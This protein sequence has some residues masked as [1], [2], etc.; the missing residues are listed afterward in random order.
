MTALNIQSV[1]WFGT[2]SNSTREVKLKIYGSDETLTLP[3]QVT[4]KVV[5]VR[6]MLAGKLACDWES[7]TFIQQGVGGKARTLRDNEEIRTN[8]LVKGAK[9]F[10]R[11]RMRWPHLHAIIGAGHAGLRQA[12]SYQ[13]EGHQNYV[14]FDRHDIVGGTAWVDNANPTS[15]LQTEL[16]V[17]HLQYDPAYPWPRGMKTQ[18]SR[19]ELL[20]HFAQV[21]EEYGITPHL[22]LGSDVQSMDVV[23]DPGDPSGFMQ[24]YHLSV[25]KADGSTPPG[26][27]AILEVSSVACFPGGLINPKRV[28]YKGEEIFEGQMGYGMFNEFDYS[29]VK[30]EGVAIIGFGAFATENVRTCVEHSAKMITIVCRRK[31][32]AM[33]RIVS[34]MTNQSFYPVPGKMCMEMMECMYELAGDDPWGYYAVVT[35]EKRITVTLRQASRFGIGDVFFLARYFGKCDVLVGT[36]KRLKRDGVQLETGETFDCQHIIKV[37]GFVGDFT[38]DKTMGIKKMEGFHVNSDFRRLIWAENPGIDAGKFGGTSF[39]PAAIATSEMQ[40]WFLNYIG[41][42]FM[43][44]GVGMLP[45][46]KQDPDAE[47]PTYIWEPR[48]GSTISMLYANCPSIGELSLPYQQFNRD[49][50]LEMHPVEQFID[51]CAEE[52]YNYAKMM[53]EEGCEKEVPPYP[54]TYAYVHEMCERQDKE[55]KEDQDRQN[56]RMMAAS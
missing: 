15:K 38:V 48:N 4:T 16:A 5:E 31:N 28:E 24:T 49:R 23:K 13:K 41:D 44:I 35:T 3:L 32:M 55:G 25:A 33:P 29:R 9:S 26:E 21:C 37:L 10:T 27:E 45:T 19:L 1:P 20:E 11:E 51:E 40:S 14:C 42:S 47:R 34:W 39:S 36:V 30:G 46:K 52:W 12:L 50:Q 43:V 56:A 22:S 54:Y 6:H 8:T 18:P 17:Y 7:F 53:K 2:K